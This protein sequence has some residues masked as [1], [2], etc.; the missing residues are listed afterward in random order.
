MCTKIVVN[1]HQE[2]SVGVMAGEALD[3]RDSIGGST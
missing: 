1:T 2:L 3:I